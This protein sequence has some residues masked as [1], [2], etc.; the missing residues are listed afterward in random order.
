MYGTKRRL[1]DVLAAVSF[2]LCT[3][4]FTAYFM[5]VA[6]S[7]ASELRILTSMSQ[8]FFEPFIAAFEDRNPDISEI[9]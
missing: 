5:S 6:V 4:V 1:Q 2:R 9:V 7:A 8:A 3:T